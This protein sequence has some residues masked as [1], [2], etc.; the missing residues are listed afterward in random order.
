MLTIEQKVDLLFKEREEM[1]RTKSAWIN[2]S[3]VMEMTGYK[4]KTLYK[5][6]S[7]QDITTRRAGCLQF[8]RASL[9]E[10]LKK[11]TRESISDLRRESVKIK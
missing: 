2:I 9:E 3:D 1:K 6:S 8:N 11:Q 7:S 10:Y 5:L 4:R